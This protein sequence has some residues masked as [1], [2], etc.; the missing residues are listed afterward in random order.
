MTRARGCN[1]SRNSKSNDQSHDQ[2]T[3]TT[4]FAVPTRISNK[5]FAAYPYWF[6]AIGGL[7]VLAVAVVGCGLLAWDGGSCVLGTD[8]EG[9]GAEEG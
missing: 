9:A 5:R 1:G 2:N 7:R 6:N 8:F 3:E 4:D